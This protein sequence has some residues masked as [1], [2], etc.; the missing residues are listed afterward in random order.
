MQTHERA[1]TSPETRRAIR[2]N[3]RALARQSRNHGCEHRVSSRT[4]PRGAGLRAGETRFRRH[5]GLRHALGLR[6]RAWQ[7]KPGPV[8]YLDDEE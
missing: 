1:I 2:G 3:Q 5:G 6:Q 4:A 8:D 7:S